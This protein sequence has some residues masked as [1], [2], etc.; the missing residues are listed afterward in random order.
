M[1]PQQLTCHNN[2]TATKQMGSTFWKVIHKQS[3]INYVHT[4]R[5]LASTQTVSVL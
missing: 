3:D 2:K 5:Y 1:T 4:H